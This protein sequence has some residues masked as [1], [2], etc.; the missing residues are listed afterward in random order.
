M[1]ADDPQ[2]RPTAH[3]VTQHPSL[4]SESK[5]SKAQLMK[6]L[7]EERFKNKLLSQ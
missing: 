1:V 7:N 6:E 4:C 5:K 2:D 3:M